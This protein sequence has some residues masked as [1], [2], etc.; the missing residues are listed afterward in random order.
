M[1]SIFD[2]GIEP[3]DIVAAIVV[4][5]VVIVMAVIGIVAIV[6]DAVRAKTK[7]SSDE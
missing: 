5:T 4:L 2:F 7:A 6:I 3:S 1:T